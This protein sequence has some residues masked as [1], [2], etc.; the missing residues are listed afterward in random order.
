MSSK[1]VPDRIGQS[2]TNAQAGE[3]PATLVC[4]LLY[5]EITWVRSVTIG[6]TAAA[7]RTCCAIAS[8]SRT[9]SV[10]AAPTPAFTPPIVVLPG[11]TIT[12]LLP[13]PAIVASMLLRAP[14]PI[15]TV[16]ITA[17]T[18][19]MIPS[20]VSSERW[21]LRSER[22]ESDRDRDLEV[23]GALAAAPCTTGSSLTTRPSRNETIRRE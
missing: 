16:T 15:A 20:T 22:A 6:V 23:H 13:R 11:S 3:T 10:E 7:C 4:Q 18:P 5:G 21:R 17:A 1:N 14:A 9:V 12:R 19:M 8:P 2:R